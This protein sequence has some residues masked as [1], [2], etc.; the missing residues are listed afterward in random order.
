MAWHGGHGFESW[1]DNWN[2]RY[3][4]RQNRKLQ[5]KMRWI[6]DSMPNQIV[7]FVT[8]FF[9]EFAAKIQ[10]IADCGAKIG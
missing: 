9:H 3:L 6:V 10:Q 1:K 7:Q 4:R 5:I 2:Q 8:Q